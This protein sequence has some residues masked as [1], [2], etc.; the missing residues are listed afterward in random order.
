VDKDGNFF[1]I[2]F[3]SRHLKDHY[4]PILPRGCGCSMGMVVFNEYFHGKQ[5]I[6]YADHRLLE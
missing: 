1:V 2:S 6:L 4:K 3:A 5:I